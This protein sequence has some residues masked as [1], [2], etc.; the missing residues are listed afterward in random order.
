M[1]TFYYN[2]F[3]P[4]VRRVWLTLLEKN[5]PFEPILIE[6]NGDQLQPEFLSV[7][8]FYHIPAIVDD[9]FR[10]IESLAILDYLEA[11]YPTPSLLPI[12]AQGI[13]IVRM[14]Q[15]LTANELFPAIVSL[16]YESEAAPQYEQARQ[17]VDQVLMFMAELLGNRSYFG[18]DQLTLADIVVGA[19]IPLLPQLNFSLTPYPQINDWYQ[20]VMN[21]EAWQK[22]QMDE[23]RF[24]VFKRRVK[25]LVRLRRRSLTAGSAKQ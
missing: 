18:G 14:T 1:L 13:A 7:N 2:P 19:A 12:E 24:E 25:V 17:R 9:G 4:N 11:K 23:E 15:M 20:R 5:I 3:S 21:R 6:L 22:T 8:P 10:V 16:I